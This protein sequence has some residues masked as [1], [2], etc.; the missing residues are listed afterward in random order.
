MSDP[1][2][3]PV[4]SDHNRLAALYDV[5]RALGTSLNLDE[6]LGIAMDA[7]IRLTKAERGFLV[8]ADPDTGDLR[9]RIARNAKNEA[10]AED[11]F[12]VSRT[13]V[14]EVMELNTPVI[15]TNAQR[16]P[17]FA[18]RESITQYALRSIMAVPLAVRGKVTG[19]LYVD[20]KVRSVMF[21][22][23]DL[24][25]LVSFAGPAAVAIENA[26][27]YTLTDAALAARVTEL[28][29]MQ[30]IDRQLNAVLDIRTVLDV[31]LGWAM[32]RT[33]AEG[34]W[35]GLV[36]ET[37]VRVEAGTG[38]APFLPLDH[39]IV[40]SAIIS[41]T[42]TRP[43][44]PVPPVGE[45]ITIRRVAPVRREDKVVAL[46][47]VERA[48]PF[49]A[50]EVEF[51]ARLADHAAIALENARLY[52][53]VKKANEAKSKFVSV[54]S[55]E[56]RLPMTSIKGYTD[57]LRAAIAGPVNEQQQ[58]FL[59]IIRT[60]VERMSVLVSD[61]SDISRVE[62]G[63][64]QLKLG[65]VNVAEAAQ[66]AS[67]SLKSQIEGKSQ[68]LTLNLPADLP[69]VHADKARVQQILSNLLSNAHKYSPSGARLTLTAEH[70]EAH[71]RVNVT[72]TGF[73]ISPAD[74][75]KLFTQFFRSDDSHIREQTG[76]GL[77]LHITKLLIELQGGQMTV[78]SELGQGS[79]FAFTLPV[80]K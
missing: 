9:F 54:V 46:I 34:G 62:T 3:A 13:V 22:K 18:D 21:S 42:G 36:E 68:T 2:P 76:W 28:Q 19:V 38:P 10:I 14:K 53:A 44:A 8:L 74:Q 72:D 49:A 71:V 5:S 7:A 35:I 39:P 69:P 32:K 47:V 15:T 79:T 51:L 20:N 33:H 29:V 66:E 65:A 23:A 6:A 30:T 61:L 24:E 52:D 80:A 57:L 64:L 59:N 26:R 16:D 1:A 55:H 75:A 41:P 37:G 43:L 60:N 4:I 58:Q 11:A 63:R 77:G 67:D 56:L 73:G 12:E 17:R 70:M 78:Q 45:R 40:Y 25:L 31:T 27:L 50:H 48:S